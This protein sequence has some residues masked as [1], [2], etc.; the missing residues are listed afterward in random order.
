MG[1]WTLWPCATKTTALHAGPDGIWCG[2]RG[3]LF[4]YDLEKRE[5]RWWTVLHGL[6]SNDIRSLAVEET[7]VVWVGTQEGLVRIDGDAWTRTTTRQGL[8][9]D[10]VR[11]VS[12]GPDGN[13][14]CVS[15]EYGGGASVRDGGAWR[16][17][18]LG[19]KERVA[20]SPSNR[21]A[22]ADFNNSGALVFDGATLEKLGPLNVRANAVRIEDAG[23]EG[24]WLRFGAFLC[25]E[26]EGDWR[27]LMAPGVPA[28]GDVGV[29]VFDAKTG[30]VLERQAG[31]WLPVASA[32][33]EFTDPRRRRPER[34]VLER[35]GRTVLLGGAGLW[36]YREGARRRLPP[37][38]YSG[39][40]VVQEMSEA[41]D[42]TVFAMGHEGCF[43]VT[44]VGI[45]P[46]MAGDR[47][48]R[49]T[50]PHIEVRRGMRCDWENGRVVETPVEVRGNVSTSMY[51]LQLF[52]RDGTGVEW[53]FGY[54]CAASLRDGALTVFRHGPRGGVM[55]AA[56]TPR[57]VFLATTSGLVLLD[58]DTGRETA[59]PAQGRKV[60][61]IAAA[62]DCVWF[63][64]MWNGLSRY[65]LGTGE[66]RRWD[67]PGAR[68]DRHNNM[69][70]CIAFRDGHV[71]AATNGGVF[72]FDPVAESW[73]RWTGEFTNTVLVDSRRD[74]WF[75]TRSGILRY[76][77]GAAEAER[78]RAMALAKAE[79][80]V[81]R[82][83]DDDPRARQAAAEA[84]GRLGAAAR[85]MLV[86]YRNHADRNVRAGVEAL[87][88]G[89]DEA[90]GSILER[91]AVVRDPLP[92]RGTWEEQPAPGSGG[93]PARAE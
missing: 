28:R 34:V 1:P 53:F 36:L 43:A 17:F 33:E 4:L 14:W 77:F 64:T 41:A 27:F 20:V 89:A 46:V 83:G 19:G 25:R 7:G 3:G 24:P 56:L 59:V 38:E 90:P 47:H 55:N 8:V 78:T 57:G 66:V 12:V 86:E 67:V 32:P 35:A 73:T 26:A 6:P 62:D 13:V 2:T 42:G 72:E 44:S 52:G 39:P 84:L 22:L 63:G 15:A 48:V 69:V 81:L 50:F 54:Y 11:G 23:D 88:A 68:A 29:T 82:L 58:P 18:K 60:Y 85:P 76:E 93:G 9:N 21:V 61:S 65:S 40:A 31:R 71:F 74:L 51:T 5:Y 30:R 37:A 16:A 91:D 92:V 10:N 75:G 79:E 45:G 49:A 70:R 87:L 80:L